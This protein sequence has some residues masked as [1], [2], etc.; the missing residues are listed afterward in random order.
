MDNLPTVTVV[1]PTYNAQRTLRGCLE[2]IEKQDYPREK[3]D[4]VIADAGSSD[5]TIK[6]IDELKSLSA[7]RYTLCANPL[8]TGEAGKAAGVK[9][10]AGDIVAFIDSDNI[11]EGADWLKRMAAPFQD[12][13]ITASEPLYYSYRKTDPFI[14][15]Y[16]A[17]IGMNDPLCLFL[18]N[19]D[20]YCFISN[21]WTGAP[22]EQSDRGDFF[23][24]TLLDRLKLPTIGANGF[25]IRRDAL[26]Q[27]GIGE[28]LFDIDIIARLMQNGK[29]RI[30]KVK[31]GIVH[32]FSDNL[33]TWVRKQKRRV[34]DYLYFSKDRKREF[35]WQK[36]EKWRLAGFIIYCVLVFP[37]V[38]QAAIGYARKPEAVWFFHPFACWIT[39]GTYAGVYITG[40]VFGVKPEDRKGWK[41]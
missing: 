33:S 9:Q 4:I 12:P 5:S 36:T 13:D 10:A 39:L 18:G 40:L 21:T 2:S 38:I 32:L 19:Y 6:I 29:V 1:I 16:G 20:R 8:K 25:L 35:P 37:L 34:K 23:K 22:V 30:A 3:L 27:C 11:L 41:Q 28:Y 15:R 24:I 26:T 17:L 14:T 7:I 31:I